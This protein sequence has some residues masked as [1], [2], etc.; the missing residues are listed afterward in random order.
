MQKL[1]DREKTQIVEL[2][3]CLCYQRLSRPTFV[4]KFFLH[5][6][7]FL[8]YLQGKQN[9]RNTKLHTACLLSKLVTSSR[10][11]ARTAACND[12]CNRGLLED[13][14]ESSTGIFHYFVWTVHIRS[15]G[16]KI[17][18]HGRKVNG[19]NMKTYRL[20]GGYWQDRRREVLC[21]PQKRWAMWRYEVQPTAPAV[22]QLDE[23]LCWNEGDQVVPC[24][25]CQPCWTAQILVG[26]YYTI[27][28][29][30]LQ[31]VRPSN[32]RL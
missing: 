15:V 25:S 31:R 30:R 14:V 2:C 29:M 12:R 23:L 1:I 6:S 32:L 19:R 26:W 3:M 11:A 17:Y 10:C 24:V 9:Y 4:I 21:G 28:W 13:I 20:A 22:S 27:R 5:A 16:H 7:S 18:L 8:V